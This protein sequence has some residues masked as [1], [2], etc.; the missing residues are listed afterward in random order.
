MQ[1]AQENL[2]I[3]A[4]SQIK[5]IIGVYE[6]ECPIFCTLHPKIS[7]V[8]E[9][10]RKIYDQVYDILMDGLNIDIE[11]LFSD[12]INSFRMIIAAFFG[13]KLAMN[14]ILPYLTEIDYLPEC[15]HPLHTVMVMCYVADTMQKLLYKKDFG[16]TATQ[17]KY[18]ELKEFVF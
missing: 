4:G 13:M 8:A 2:L 7:D 17:E 11:Q 1:T 12:D 16:E 6:A 15:N 9:L 3:D 5:N 14:G 10:N 18:R